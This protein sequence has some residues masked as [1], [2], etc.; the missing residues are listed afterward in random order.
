MLLRTSYYIR[1]A[2]II[3]DNEIGNFELFI[4]FCF[5]TPSTAGVILCCFLS[6]CAYFV[7]SL[8]F[9]SLADVTPTQTIF[10]FYFLF[11]YEDHIMAFILQQQ[12]KKGRRRLIIQQQ[13]KKGRR[14]IIQQ[15]FSC[16]KST[17]DSGRI[18]FE[19]SRVNEIDSR[20][21]CLRCCWMGTLLLLLLLLTFEHNKQDILYYDGIEECDHLRFTCTSSLKD[22]QPTV[23]VVVRGTLYSR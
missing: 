19:F 13:E 2:I 5:M 15:Y 23:G 7:L 10:I 22:C 12:E 3:V 9:L 11:V 6:W 21:F 20:V 8:H 1:C 18:S 17:I 4:I 16:A 14:L